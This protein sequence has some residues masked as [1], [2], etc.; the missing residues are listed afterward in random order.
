MIVRYVPRF[1]LVAAAFVGCGKAPAPLPLPPASP[2][3]PPPTI[4]AAAVDSTPLVVFVGTSLTA[5]YGLPDV[6]LAYPNLIQRK[7][8]SLNLGYRVVNRGISGE[9]SAGA[10]ARIDWVL[11]M[12]I[13]RVLIV[14]TGANDGLRGQPPDS[15]RANIQA[16]L[17][18]AKQLE[19]PPKLVLTGM[20]ALPNLGDVY[21]R[22][23]R[24]IFPELAKANGTALVP[25]L[26]ETVAGVDTLNQA[27]GIHPNRRGHQIVAE[28]VWR[29]LRGVLEQDRQR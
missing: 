23:F 13:I 24:V 11:R 4:A 19:P 25:F 12:G 26:L 5:G 22:Q 18:R 27:D 17:D 9:T 2:I 6:N 3:A 15:T 20:E 28:N 10:L 7:V 21:T 16:I 14:E 1:M 29:V 8:D